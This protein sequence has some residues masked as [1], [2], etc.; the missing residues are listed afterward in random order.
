MPSHFMKYFTIALLSLPIF[1]VPIPI[2]NPSFEEGDLPLVGNGQFSQVIPFSVIA[3]SGGTLPGWN[4]STS[5]T[6]STFGGFAPS[7]ASVN[8]SSP[9]WDGNNIA[10][11][12]VDAMTA[13][14]TMYQELTTP[15]VSNAVYTLSAEIGR[16]NFTPAF[17]YSMALIAGFA[18][19][20]SADVSLSGEGHGT[21][22]LVYFS[23]PDNPFAG[24]LLLIRFAVFYSGGFT[25]AFFDDVRLDV[26]VLDDS[27]GSVPEPST[28]ALCAAGLAAIWVKRRRG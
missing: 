20:A 19:L 21:D 2:Q 3:G 12:Q 11:I 10:Y 14:V 25:E 28:Y 18:G 16:R 24:N 5:T 8:W 1:A 9:W 26:R 4:Y 13:G 22:Q 23:P 15:L 7:A 27:G 6:R 17:N